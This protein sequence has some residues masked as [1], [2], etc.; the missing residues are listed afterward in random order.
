MAITQMN[1]EERDGRTYGVIGAAMEVHRLLGPGL[2]ETA[3][4]EAIAIE[5]ERRRIRFQRKVL[6]PIRYIR[7]ALYRLRRGRISSSSTKSWWN[8][9]CAIA[10]SPFSN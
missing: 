1:G 2:L 8:P 4:Q 7:E 9:I 6:I 5:F 3:Y 10:F